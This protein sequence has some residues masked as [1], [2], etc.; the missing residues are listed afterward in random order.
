M[1]SSKAAVLA[2]K[3]RSQLQN[4]SVPNIHVDQTEVR[5]SKRL[6]KQLPVLNTTITIDP[7]LP[8]FGCSLHELSP[9]AQSG[10]LLVAPTAE[11]RL[12]LEKAQV[13]AIIAATCN[14]PREM[15]RDAVESC[16]S[17][18]FV[19]SE[20]I[21]GLHGDV[22]CYK[23]IS[24]AWNHSK[25]VHVVLVPRR[26]QVFAGSL[27]QA[28]MDSARIGTTHWA[29][30][31]DDDMWMPEKTE[32]Q[33]GAMLAVGA[34]MSSSDAYVRAEVWRCSPDYKYISYNQTQRE[35][36]MVGKNWNAMNGGRFKS[37]LSEKFNMPITQPFP[38]VVTRLNIDVHNIYVTSAVILASCRGLH[39]NVN[40]PNG[41]EDYDMWKRALR[42]Q[43]G[44]WI[45][46]PLAIYSGAEHRTSV[47]SDGRCTGG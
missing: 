8:D 2:Q 30:L 26:T 40:L 4:F 23:E 22:S 37:Y 33:L 10:D 1:V 7:D 18:T 44:L 6:T 25:K 5:E 11:V 39:F 24:N 35:I 29:F 12:M 42:R 34:S 15:L 45:G 16:L 21:I 43:D 31:D 38:M 14:R 32:V 9:P 27:R 36:R 41:Q 47:D 13:V 17:Q 20:I 28:A 3:G 19:L 46:R